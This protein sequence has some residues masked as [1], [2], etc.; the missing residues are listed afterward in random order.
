MYIQ[1]FLCIYKMIYKNFKK[2]LTYM[3]I[4]VIMYIQSDIQNIGGLENVD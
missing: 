3:Y 4:G 2:G 1:E